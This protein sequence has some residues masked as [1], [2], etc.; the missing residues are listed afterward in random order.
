MFKVQFK[1]WHVDVAKLHDL[2]TQATVDRA[3]VIPGVVV[4]HNEKGM[5]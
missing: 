3:S 4:V 2:L 1:S 5:F